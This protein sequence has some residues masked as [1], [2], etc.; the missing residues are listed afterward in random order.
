VLIATE[1][2]TARRSH[3]GTII[4]DS[5]PELFELWVG[6]LIRKLGGQPP[7]AEPGEGLLFLNAWNEWAEG[8]H[9][10]PCQRWNRAYLEALRRA[11]RANEPQAMPPRLSPQQ[12]AHVVPA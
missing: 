2:F 11:I 4:Y 8:N 6:G 9:L 1:Q 7:I 10:E 12:T 5:T 3:G